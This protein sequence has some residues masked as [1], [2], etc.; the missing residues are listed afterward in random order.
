M[1]RVL[2][3]LMIKDEVPQIIEALPIYDESRSQEIIEFAEKS[4]CN[5]IYGPLSGG[6]FTEEQLNDIML[7][8]Y[9]VGVRRPDGG[10]Y[11]LLWSEIEE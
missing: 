4:I 3:I 7:H 6:L 1:V 2:N 9:T 8:A 5:W 11:Y 10:S